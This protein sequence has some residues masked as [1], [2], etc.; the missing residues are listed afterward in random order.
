[1]TLATS[2]VPAPV[3]T[4]ATPADN[5]GAV[6]TSANI[7]LNFSAAVHAGSG[8]I[9]I[10]DGATQTYMGRDGL[11]HTRLVG[12][13]DTRTVSISDASQVTIDGNQVTINLSSDLKAGVSYSVQMG[14]GVLLGES[15][16]S[17][18]GLADATKLNFAVSAPAIAAPT[19]V[20]DTLSMRSWGSEGPFVTNIA[21][22]H[23]SGTFQGALHSGEKVEV[24]IDGSTWH[25]AT[26]DGNSWSYDATIAASGTL[27]ARVSNS[28]GASTDA[29]SHAYTYDTTG[30]TIASISLDKEAL[31]VGESARLTVVF[32]EKVTGLTTEAFGKHNSSVSSLEASADGKTWTAIVTMG[33]EGLTGG[34]VALNPAAVKDGAGNYGSG[35]WNTVAYA[36]K[37][38]SLASLAVTL[39][40]GSDTDSHPAD[41]L[42][43]DDTPTVHLDIRSAAGLIA[44]DIIKIY[45]EA[46]ETVI[47]T[48]T[49]TASD[50]GMYGGSIDITVDGE[51]PLSEGEHHLVAYASDALGV[52]GA[53]TGTALD[54]TIDT[55]GPRISHTAPVSN[56]PA[57][58][59]GLKTIT[60]TFSEDIDWSASDGVV[61]RK[62]QSEPGV[63]ISF[64]TP[65]PTGGQVA[66]YNYLTYDAETHVLTI[67]LAQPL[68]AAGTYSIRSAG[69]VWDM[70]HNPYANE[71]ALLSFLINS[72]SQVIP[73]APTLAITE[74]GA[75]G[76]G[77][78][79]NAT[80]MVSGITASFWKYSLDGGESYSSEQQADGGNVVFEIPNDGTYEAGKILVK[81]YN[82]AG[83]ESSAGSLAF[84]L[85]LDRVAPAAAVSAVN[86]F[87][88]DAAAISGSYLGTL[89]AGDTIQYSV[90]GSDWSPATAADGA[91]TASGVTL[92]SSGT[93]ALRVADLAGNVGTNPHAAD[94]SPTWFGSSTGGNHSATASTVLIAGSGNDVVGLAGGAAAYLD[95]GAGQDTLMLIDSLNLASVAGK[96]KNFETIVVGNNLTLALGSTAAVTALNLPSSIVPGYGLLTI[97][98][99]TNAHVDLAGTGGWQ[100]VTLLNVL[101]LGFNA[102]SDLLNGHHIY[103]N[104]GA[105]LI[106]VVGSPTVDN[107]AGLA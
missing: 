33:N 55:T 79:S 51:H 35:E 60:L 69:N 101:T 104:P 14:S 59:P 65:P 75:A 78:T 39:D 87:G 20:V 81:Q 1:M 62:D 88:H 100:E 49:L 46:S 63:E 103:T 98:G 4:S 15:G 67:N 90:N 57:V 22:Q 38:G 52:R 11:M 107:M 48:H 17:Y 84:D 34:D 2:T 102:I 16:L 29:L 64:E 105:H 93:I 86:S 56:G 53:A 26:V 94:S 82:V 72:E 97:D 40:K 43:R 9:T 76:D 24:S 13:T 85:K 99:A 37:P 12:A 30:P 7:V 74:T 77:V 28:A 71:G 106:M 5:A 80:I 66:D 54:I 83:Q 6:S 41:G 18:A 58:A 8:Y 3:L 21:A 96:I 19:A 89:Q 23:F 91:W 42:T 68:T 44:G 10:S 36:R 32:S 45:D 95:G 47:G 70:A 50:F 27:R 31:S 25:A 73:L 92:D 61:I